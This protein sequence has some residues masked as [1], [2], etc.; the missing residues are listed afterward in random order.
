MNADKANLPANDA[1]L[2]SRTFVVTG[3]LLIALI[4]GFVL[5]S[6]KLTRREPSH[7]GKPLSIWIQELRTDKF[8]WARMEPVTDEQ[9][10][11]AIRSIGEPAVP[12]L[13]SWLKSSL[14][15][16][17]FADLIDTL[18]VD[19]TKVRSAS[20]RR[21]YHAFLG[22]TAL[23]SN[24]SAA[25]PAMT[26]LM[27]NESTALLAAGVLAAIGPAGVP[28]LSNALI[29]NNSKISAAAVCSAGA[30]GK[31]GEPLIPLL[32]NVFTN[33]RQERV[34]RS[35]A[36]RALGMIGQ[37]PETVLPVLEA[38]LGD[39]DYIVRRGAAFGLL[40]MDTAY[41]RLIPALETALKTPSGKLDQWILMAL[42]CM[43]KDDLRVG[44]AL[45][46]E[47]TFKPHNSPVFK[48]DTGIVV[49]SE[50]A[51]VFANF[52]TITNITSQQLIASRRTL[53]EMGPE[54]GSE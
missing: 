17:R 18:P 13:T 52:R 15:I 31:S 22:L 50:W 14:D 16:E 25:I 38:G 8:D 43:C 40:L 47:F 27:F 44:T 48:V 26:N 23:G 41:A 6:P 51:K 46:N 21:G 29:S 53:V 20:G 10:A 2:N 36:A 9:A 11:L 42:V 33:T 7:L 49:S 54:E 19:L 37:S 39:H 32:V 45:T 5:I 12:F 34:T 4:L 3:C 28:V 35:S 24:A 1:S 30:L